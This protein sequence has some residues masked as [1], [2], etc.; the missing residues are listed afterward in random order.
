MWTCTSIALTV[1]MYTHIKSSSTIRARA[2]C[3]H[4]NGKTD[5]QPTRIFRNDEEEK[6]SFAWILCACLPLWM[7]HTQHVSK[8]NYLIQFYKN[9]KLIYI[10][11][12]SLLLMFTRIEYAIIERT[13]AYFDSYLDKPFWNQRVDRPNKTH[14]IKVHCK[15]HTCKWDSR[16]VIMAHTHTHNLW[17]LIKIQTWYE[18]DIVWK[19]RK[20]N[21]FASNIFARMP[22]CSWSSMKTTSDLW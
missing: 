18:W 10:T 6:S 5:G 12:L 21:K 7:K 11:C 13:R 2:S 19:R 4:A 9:I 15:F 8:R 3:P 17:T 14:E 16:L 1:P 22:H 20:N